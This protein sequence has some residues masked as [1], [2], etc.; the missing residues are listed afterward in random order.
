MNMLRRSSNIPQAT[1]INGLPPTEAAPSPSLS[2][3]RA[4]FASCQG[5]PPLRVPP[6]I[7]ALETLLKP[8]FPSWKDKG[9]L[10]G[11]PAHESR[12]AFFAVHQRPLTAAGGL[13]PVSGGKCRRVKRF[14][15]IP[16]SPSLPRLLKFECALAG[17][18]ERF[19]QFGGAGSGFPVGGLPA[20]FRSDVPRGF[21]ES[22]DGARH[23][24]VGHI[25]GDAIINR[26]L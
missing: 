25:I 11:V 5:F 15:L 12:A 9:V 6:L 26:R 23:A 24:V 2:V 3:S 18:P 14:C 10:Q 19:L 22:R 8:A 20:G 16:V 13:Y 17:R 4:G 21:H 7:A 1:V